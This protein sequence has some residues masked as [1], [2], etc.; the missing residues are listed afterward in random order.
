MKAIHRFIFSLIALSGM[1]ITA[2]TD[3]DGATAE[4]SKDV[5]IKGIVAYCPS[6]D[7]EIDELTA[8]LNTATSLITLTTTPVYSNETPVDL[9][10][11][12]I[13]ITLA[14]G[15]TSDLKSTYNL[16]DGNTGKLIIT[17]RIY[18]KYIFIG[19]MPIVLPTKT[20]V[21]ESSTAETQ[22]IINLTPIPPPARE[23]ISLKFM[24]LP[25]G[26]VFQ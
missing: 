1:L 20:F 14:K 25:R 6:E 18:M 24:Y 10:N 9:S 15:A 17:A 11:V 2:C 5:T 4:K 26:G 8:S 22:V 23:A 7:R 21:A 3:K 16:A 19:S 12:I 13:Q